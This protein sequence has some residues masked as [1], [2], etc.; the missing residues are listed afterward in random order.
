MNHLS[1]AFSG[2]NELRRS[3]SGDPRR[4]FMRKAMIVSVAALLCLSAGARADSLAAYY[5]VVS[6]TDHDFSQGIDGG[7]VTGL[8]QSTLVGG[9]PVAST[10]GM[11]G[12]FASGPFK[13]LTGL[14]QLTWWSP[15]LNPNVTLDTVTTINLP[16]DQPS[17][18]F[19]TGQT[20]DANGFRTAEFVGTFTGTSISFTN[21]SSDDDL[22]VFVDGNLVVD[23]GGVKDLASGGVPNVTDSGLSNGTHTLEIFYADR[24]QVQAGLTLD[25]TAD[26]LSAPVPEPT[27]L[28]LFGFGSLGIAVSAWRRRKLA[29][30]ASAR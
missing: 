25:I 11:T 20:T 9:L 6:P 18:F 10:L 1:Q 30:L 15:S 2:Q 22:W 24:H 29:N 27:S 12:P 28:M 17:N 23:D 3:M 14:N 21:I 7:P 4:I 26:N 8:V 19:P 16:I 13:D 5:Y